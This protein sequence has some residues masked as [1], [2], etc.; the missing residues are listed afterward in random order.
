M[1]EANVPLAMDP[2]FHDVAGL[3]D[4]LYR[5]WNP[6]AAGPIHSARNRPDR[7]TIWPGDLGIFGGVHVCESLVGMDHRP[8]RAPPGNGRGSSLLDACLGSARLCLRLLVFRRRARS[9]R[10]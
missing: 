9:S 2:G 10:I 5:P 8:N 6:G 7:A 1:I 3:A 4:Q